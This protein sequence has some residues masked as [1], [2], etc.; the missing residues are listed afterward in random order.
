[1]IRRLSAPIVALVLAITSLVAP[2]AVAQTRPAPASAVGKIAAVVNDDVITVA[3]LQMRL[4]LAL[5]SSG[6]PA[7]P[8]AQQRMLPQVLRLLIDE[9]L[10][11]QEAKRA[12]ISVPA[13]DVDRALAA[14]AGQNR[15]S[16]QQLFTM[17]KS[18]GV[19][20][21]ALEDQVR[22][23]LAWRQLIQRRFVSQVEV[24]DTQVD[25]VVERLKAN[26][27][28]PQFL[29][30]SIFLAVDQDAGEGQVKALADRLVSEI[31]RGAPFPAVAR[32]FSQAAGAQ[33]GGDMGW[34]LAGQ[35]EPALDQVLGTMQQGQVSDP[36]RTLGGYNILLLRDKRLVNANTAAGVKVRLNQI[37]VPVPPT[38]PANRVQTVVAQ[39]RKDF[40]GVNGCEAFRA[41]AKELGVTANPDLGD[42][43]LSR[44]PDGMRQVA[45]ALPDGQVS[46]PI[47]GPDGVAVMMICS[48]QDA[49]GDG[50][51]R[52]QIRSGLAE[53]KLDMMQR[54]LLRDL[55][56]N[57]YID[58]RL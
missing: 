28:K 35:L 13:Q 12:G 41:K 3:D 16:T 14:I 22:S 7:T 38:A 10:Q 11:G 32:Q 25:E 6:L 55:R 17:L 33:N 9:K 53:Q 5:M 27:G 46:S 24:S 18:T 58:I 56:G 37:V 4:R 2:A 49:G 30:A 34:V 40:S 23:Q 21:S 15:M 1:M 8:D 20:Q 52:D 57:A 48:R 36:I 26:Q 50:V 29:V 47:R 45:S 43:L 39:M 44:L 31:R 54:R 19:P 42:V 51:D